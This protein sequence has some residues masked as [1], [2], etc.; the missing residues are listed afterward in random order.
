[1]ATPLNPITSM[2]G[3]AQASMNNP[4]AS[5]VPQPQ[6]LIDT[7]Q[8][9]VIGAI[10]KAL[11]G[12][13]QSYGWTS[14]PPEQRMQAQQ[15]EQQK[16]ETMSRLAQ[17]AAYQG[18]ELENRKNLATIAQQ[19]ADTKSEEVASKE[20]QR[21]TANDIKQQQVDLANDKN[22]WMKDM[23]AGRLSAAQARISNQAAQFERTFKLRSQQVGIEQAKLELAQQGMDIKKGFLDLA[24]TA[25]QQRGTAEGLNTVTKLQ[26]LAYEHPILSQV[27]GLDD[28]TKAVSES[29]GAGIPGVGATAPPTVGAP[30]SAPVQTPAPNKI[31]A[32]RNAKKPPA[33]S[34]PTFHYDAQGNR[35]QGPN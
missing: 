4:A 13:A 7:T 12:A 19:N 21:K 8:H 15:M 1:M 22:E 6:G 3:Q 33:S 35:V 29:K 18:G 28:V 34:A 23:A 10:I 30:T 5:N 26:G 27:F 2:M 9:P 16:A 32:K 25:L 31:D 11:S 20:S 17:T 14:M 24:G